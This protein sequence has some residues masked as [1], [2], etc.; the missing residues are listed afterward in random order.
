LKC[1]SIFLIIEILTRRT[2]KGK[3]Q[4][5]LVDKGG[6]DKRDRLTFPAPD[7]LKIKCFGEAPKIFGFGTKKKRVMEVAVSSQISGRGNFRGT[8]ILVLA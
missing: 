6:E 8:P 7:L 4:E 1:E 5:S 3:G 2:S